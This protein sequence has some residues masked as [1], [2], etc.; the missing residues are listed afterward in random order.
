MT[1][2]TK[3]VYRRSNVA[4][5][6][7]GLM[8]SSIPDRSYRLEGSRI[9][10]L[11]IH[12][13]GGTPNELKLVAK[14]LNR[15]GYTVACCQLAGH[16][17]T[18]D[19]LVLTNWRDWSGSVTA[20][21]DQLKADCDHVYVGGLSMGA[22]LAVELASRRHDDLAGMLLYAPTLQYDGWSIPWY[23]FF[24][25][26]AMMTPVGKYYR[27]VER[28][29]YGIKDARLRARIVSAMTRGDSAEAGVL[30]T[31]AQCVKE[32]WGLVEVVKRRLN[33]IETPALIVHARDD[34]VSSLRNAE[35]IARSLRGPAEIVVLD[36]SYHLVTMDRQRDV[37]I[38]RSRQFIEAI[39]ERRARRAIAVAEPL[40]W[41]VA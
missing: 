20:A 19:D 28:E 7:S 17:G 4:P 29:P 30:G 10:V 26:L 12:G 31:P 5:D 13:L 3:Q 6:V 40:A 9:G 27:F 41:T 36:D 11:L 8:A 39:E 21:F 16:C 34:D 24:L 33:F 2:G 35:I 32:L 14:G 37:V 23:A 38:D 22:I 18:E 15:A 1:G 25:K